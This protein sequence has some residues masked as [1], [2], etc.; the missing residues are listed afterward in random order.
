MSTIV[1]RSRIIRAAISL[2][3]S[4]AAIAAFTNAAAQTAAPEGSALEEVVVT[5]FRGSL[6]TAL[7]EK[8]SETAA[9]DVIAAEDIGKFPDSNLAE[10][11]Q[12]IP[13]VDAVARRRRRRPQHL[14]ARPRP[15]LHQGAHQRHGRRGADRLQRHL[16]R[17]QQRPQLRLQ[18]LP[19][20]NLLAARRAQDAVGGR[21]GRLARRH[22][23][24]ASAAAASITTDDQVFSIT[25]RG[26]YNE[27]SEDVDPRVSML[28]VARSSSTTP[29]ACWPP[30][31]FQ[32]R[33][34]REVGYSAV[35]ILFR[36]QRQEHRH[37]HGADPSAVLHADRLDAHRS[38]PGYRAR[39][40]PTAA[41]LQHRQS[42]H[43]Q[44]GGVQRR[45]TT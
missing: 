3:L 36:H 23:R 31:S 15:R 24:P 8:R 19:D 30:S 29:S 28:D 39:A 6:N 9:I 1:H 18:R 44:H 17:R 12:R 22:R 43:Q 4:T 14:G 35:D 27:I 37:G 21:R 10:S 13:G 7:A 11:M 41:E 20:R 42:A 33:H 38:E 34:I 26:I 40:A 45:S 16:R 5:G 32:E 25:G 2:T